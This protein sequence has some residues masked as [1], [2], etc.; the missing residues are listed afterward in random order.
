MGCRRCGRKGRGK[1]GRTSEERG[2]K[3][4]WTVGRPPL[5]GGY[6]GSGRVKGHDPTLGSGP[7][8]PHAPSLNVRAPFQWC[9]GPRC[10]RGLLAAE[11]LHS[12]IQTGEPG[13][14]LKA[15]VRPKGRRETSALRVSLCEERPDEGREGMDTHLAP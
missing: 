9:R 15:A 2:Y 4:A 8:D 5:Y 10:P 7:Q 3:A 11:L 14:V 13:P 1:Q 6:K 12:P